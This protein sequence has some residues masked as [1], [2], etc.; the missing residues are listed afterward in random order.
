MRKAELK[1]AIVGH[2]N[3][4]KTSLLRTLLHND[5]FGEVQNAPGTTRHV[6][7]ARLTLSDTH[8]VQWYDTPGLEDSIALLEYIDRLSLQ[9]GQRLDPVASIEKFLASPES[10]GRFEQEARVLKRLMAC[11]AGLYVVDVRDPVLPRHKDELAVLNRCGKPLIPILNFLHSE[12][13]YLTQW[14]DNFA[15][16]G[17]HVSIEFDTVA[18]ALDGEVQLYQKLA[19]VLEEHKTILHQLAA[20]T[21]QERRQRRQQACRR[22][23]ELLI[24]VCAFRRRSQ[25]DS[26]QAAEVWQT[27]QEEVRRAEKDFIHDLLRLYQFDTAIYQDDPLLLQEGRWGM[28]L[29]SQEAIKDMGIQLSKGIATGATAGMA[30]DL[31]TGGLSLGAATLIGGLAG[32][33]WQ[34]ADKWG[35]RLMG[36]LQG[37]REL[38]VD[39][40]VLRHLALRGLGL[41]KRLESRGHAAQTPLQQVALEDSPLKDQSLPESLSEARGSTHWSALNP[42]FRTSSRRQEAIQSLTDYLQKQL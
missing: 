30:I 38:T 24:N 2:T 5:H 3:T 9:N 35:S 15:R 37:Y 16:L 29:F 40:A 7:G 28:D 31:F 21:D 13:N 4:G 1:L 36:H 34:G 26:A 20:Q 6:E 23:A 8:G 11:D 42:D 12:H 22:L 14:K 32:G 33:L 27:M 19:L 39:E 25:P 17:I 41:I 18:P 10:Q